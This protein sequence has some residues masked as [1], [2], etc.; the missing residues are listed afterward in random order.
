MSAWKIDLATIISGF[1]G[2][3]CVKYLADNKS[4]WDPNERKYISDG[5][6]DI[7]G[8]LDISKTLGKKC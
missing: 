8:G 6:G 3:I 7:V 2:K 5:S 4:K 1:I